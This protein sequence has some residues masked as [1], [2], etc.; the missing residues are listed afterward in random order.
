VVKEVVVEE[1]ECHVN[2]YSLLM[3][4]SI[5]LSVDS[6]WWDAAHSHTHARSFACSLAR[7]LA[8]RCG[9]QWMRVVAWTNP[10][11]G[12]VNGQ[13]SIGKSVQRRHGRESERKMGL[14]LRFQVEVDVRV[15][16]GV[17]VQ[18]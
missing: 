16:V 9:W 17:G 5:G 6:H 15:R 12:L 3:K 10:F 4:P 14:T 18:V 2:L 13:W 8:T 11:V 7:S 1:G